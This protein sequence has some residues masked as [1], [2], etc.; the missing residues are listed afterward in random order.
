MGNA[1]DADERTAQK[2]WTKTDPHILNK[3]KV[4]DYIQAVS[5]ATVSLYYV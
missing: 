5:G 1:P 4:P 2:S 3:A